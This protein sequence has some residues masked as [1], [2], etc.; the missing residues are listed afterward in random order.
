[1]PMRRLSLFMLLLTPLILLAIPWP[2]P[3]HAPEVALPASQQF[4]YSPFPARIERIH[5]PGL[6]DRG[7]ELVRFEA[8][9]LRLQGA[10]IST[11]IRALEHRLAGLMADTQG[12]D[13]Q[14]TLIRSQLQALHAQMR[15]I[16]AERQRLSITANF[17]GRWQDV[18]PEYRPGTWVN[19]Q[20]TLGVLND[21]TRWLVDAYVTQQDI[22][23]IQAGAAATFAQHGQP[24][25]RQAQVVFVD[26]SRT[27][28]LPHRLLD[29]RYGGPIA[30]LDTPQGN[31]VPAAPLYRVRLA[32]DQPLQT[33]RQTLG[34]VQIDAAPRSL[35]WEGTQWFLTVLIRE[36]GF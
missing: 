18:S 31:A 25:V 9:D 6:V 34:S 7:A 13:R 11:N 36:S 14:R 12:G 29:S 10:Q 27:R 17:P 28:R 22:A 24:A 2:M 20:T 35:L 1:M 3:I 33:G 8:P 19:Q 15:A 32:L 21:P 5:P 26:S 4:A 30:L 16:E 23:R